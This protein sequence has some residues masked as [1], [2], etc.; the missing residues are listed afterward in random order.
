MTTKPTDVPEQNSFHAVVDGLNMNYVCV[1]KTELARLRR[2]AEL[3]NRLHGIDWNRVSPDD[4][5]FEELDKADDELYALLSAQPKTG[6][7]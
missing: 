6:D 3:A 1:P 2:I 4:P 7:V 5:D